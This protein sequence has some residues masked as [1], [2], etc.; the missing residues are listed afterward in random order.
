MEARRGGKEERGWKSGRWKKKVEEWEEKWEKKGGA[1]WCRLNWFG[2]LRA[3]SLS[4]FLAAPV[5]CHSRPGSTSEEICFPPLCL[6]LSKGWYFHPRVFHSSSMPPPSHSLIFH[7]VTTIQPCRFQQAA[8]A[9]WIFFLCAEKAGFF[10]SLPPSFSLLLPFPIAC[11]L[12]MHPLHISHSHFYF[13]FSV[14]ANDSYLTSPP[15][16]SLFPPF[17]AYLCSSSLPYVLSPS[18][19]LTWVPF[20]ET[21]IESGGVSVLC[22]SAP[23]R[24]CHGKRQA[25]FTLNIIWHLICSTFCRCDERRRME[26]LPLLQETAP[27]VPPLVCVGWGRRAV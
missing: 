22:S 21:W 14:S 11:Y 20:D 26:L 1:G 7:T 24:G 8:W 2:D 25:L 17:L 5:L 3:C 6:F 27:I 15:L 19:P 10:P 12:S 4:C 23:R 18:L 16:F 9:Y 13:S